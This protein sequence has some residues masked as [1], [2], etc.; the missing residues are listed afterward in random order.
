MLKWWCPHLCALE[1]PSDQV[2]A[3]LGSEGVNYVEVGH[4][5]WG[6]FT[7]ELKLPS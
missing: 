5:G 3:L 1:G 6:W 7:S 2:L 4:P